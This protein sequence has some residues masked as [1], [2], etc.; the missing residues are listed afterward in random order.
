[1][2]QS[3]PF[4]TYIISSNQI[5]RAHSDNIIIKNGLCSHRRRLGRLFNYHDEFIIVTSLYPYFFFK[6][7]LW[8]IPAAS[9]TPQYWM[10]AHWNPEFWPYLNSWLKVPLK[11][12]KPTATPPNLCIKKFRQKYYL[13]CSSTNSTASTPKRKG[14]KMLYPQKHKNLTEVHGES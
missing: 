12:H 2:T 5:S 9:C 13:H 7:F 1:M 14:S 10:Y 3:N 6:L 8:P 4:C 11:N